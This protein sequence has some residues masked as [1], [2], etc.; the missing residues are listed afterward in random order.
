MST[1]PI[2]TARRPGSPSGSHPVFRGDID[3]LR[4]LAIVVVVG[5][6]IGLP[7]FSGGFVG[8]DAFFVIS[9]FLIT[10]VL[11]RE[12]T[13]PGGVRLLNFWGRRIRRLVPALG[14]VIVSSLVLA[15]LTI[16]AVGM[17]E[18]ARQSRSASLYLSNILYARDA[19]DYF[20]VDASNSPFLHTWS[21]G[22]EEQFYLFWPFLVLVVGALA[23]RSERVRPLAVGA[24]AVV[25]VG[26]FATSLNLTESGS[27]WA[28]FGLQARL[29]ELAAGGLLAA[30]PTALRSRHALVRT[31]EAALGIALVLFATVTLTDETPFPGT[32]A[33]LPV[34]GTILVIHAGHPSVSH[35]RLPVSRT[36]ARRPLQFVG[37]LSYSWYLWHWPLIV[38]AVAAFDD[39]VGVRLAAA[40][41]SLG[42]AWVAYVWVECPVRFSP[43]LNKS[44]SKTY[45][46]GALVTLIAIGTSFAVARASESNQ[47]DLDED[48]RIAREGRREYACVAKTSPGGVE[49]CEAG[50]VGSDITVMLV[51]DSFSRQW[52]TALASAAD[53]E[54]VR[55]IDRF[56][57]RCPTID[58]KIATDDFA[59]CEQFRSESDRL[60]DELAPDVVI[61][62]NSDNY[63]KGLNPFDIPDVD[64]SRLWEEALGDQIDALH[65]RGIGVGVIRAN[66]IYAIDPIECVS[67]ERSIE[68]CEMSRA[69]ALALAPEVRAGTSSALESRPHV[70]VFSV[71]EVLCDEDRCA[72]AVDGVLAYSD[73]HHLS[74]AFTAGQEGG[75]RTFV[76]E[77]TA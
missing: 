17:D 4:A 1:S 26:S 48:L 30:A 52:K 71:L 41:A 23:V 6:H 22:V 65:D 27:P 34:L 19:S 44:L 72:I 53:A 55:L 32:A 59:E 50:D 60:I 13:G 67:I 7:G 39:R 16:P 28:F 33:I 37:R 12:Q 62:S 9:G 14:L 42:V 61:L 45:L 74:P 49:Y 18:V 63:T 56:F 5:Y 73:K 20:A 43:A 24:F 25:L 76:R 47:T 31:I 11:L 70:P 64:V 46:M 36:L 58:L 68:A 66:P 77:V 35:E 21:L 54:G 57:P 51:G 69:Q 3:G 38:F 10:G 8:V 40:I 75:L 2:A 29:W 15:L